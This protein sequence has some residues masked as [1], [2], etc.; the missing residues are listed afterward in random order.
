LDDA[1]I[2]KFRIDVLQYRA[3]LV[4]SGVGIAIGL[5]VILCRS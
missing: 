3:V 1:L 2:A 4:G 5:G